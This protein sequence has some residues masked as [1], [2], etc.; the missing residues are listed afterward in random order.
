MN[1]KLDI[2]DLNIPNVCFSH[3]KTLETN[4]KRLKKFKKQRIERGFDD[5]ELWNLDF[6]IAKFILPRLKAFKES[7]HGI[8]L[9][10]IDKII[11]AFDIK[12]NGNFHMTD[13]EYEKWNEGIK[14]FSE[15]FNGLW[16]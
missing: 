16:N 9:E 11:L 14:L 5:S 12:V 7:G 1:Q 6:T 4:D 13:E 10:I 2:L 3:A 8:E 15:Y